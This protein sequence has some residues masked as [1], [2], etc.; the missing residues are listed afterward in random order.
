MDED[1]EIKVSQN[2]GFYGLDDFTDFI[3]NGMKI[4]VE[5]IRAIRVI[6]LIPALFGRQALFKDKEDRVIK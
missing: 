4:W 5:K 1:R 6:N 3:I 2:H